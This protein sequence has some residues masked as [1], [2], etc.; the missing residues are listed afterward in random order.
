MRQGVPRGRRGAV[1]SLVLSTKKAVQL[2]LRFTALRV[3]VC[4]VH[5]VTNSQGSLCLCTVAARLEPRLELLLWRRPHS[6]D[7]QAFTFHFQEH[8]NARG[9][10][11]RVGVTSRSHSVAAAAATG[12]AVVGEGGRHLDAAATAQPQ[13]G[14]TTKLPTTG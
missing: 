1:T 11:R 8:T 10:R 12:T 7:S 9:R 2:Y 13:D 6:G 5:K 14:R 3:S 4:S